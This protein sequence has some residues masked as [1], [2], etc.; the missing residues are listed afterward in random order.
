VAGDFYAATRSPSGKP[1][2]R[3]PRAAYFTDRET[4]LAQLLRDLQP[5]RVVTLCGPGG[6][7]KTA[8][9]AEAIWRLMPE[10][11]PPAAFPD[12]VIFYSF[13]GRPDPALAFEH[14]VRSYDETAQD[15]SAGAVYRL[16]SNKRAL[17]VLDGA[18]E[19][20]NLG[21]VLDV[22]AGCGVLVTSRRREDAPAGRQDLAPLPQTEALDL[23]RAWGQAQIDAEAAGREICDLLGGLP[24]AVRLAGRYLAQTGERATEYRAWLA[25]TPLP[26]LDHGARRLESVNVLLERSLAQVSEDAQQLLAVTG[27]LALAPFDRAVIAAALPDID[28]RPALGQLVNYGLLRRDTARYTVSH[29]L[30]HTYARQRLV[31]AELVERVGR[32]YK[33]LC[34]RTQR[35]GAGR[36]RPPG[37]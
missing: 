2:Q 11:E 19:A 32:Y 6:M 12:G 37:S 8:L 4:E 23:L 15:S 7:G 34:S 35:S 17:L 14:L 30:I 28:L 9:A 18:E 3:P 16:L 31:V 26:A 13:Y 10:P 24:L 25:E 20:G 5:G 21:T 33:R 27:S 29:A 1:L 36:L 22:T